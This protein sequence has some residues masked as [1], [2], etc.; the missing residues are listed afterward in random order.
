MLWTRPT[1]F[2]RFARLFWT[3]P[4]PGLWLSSTGCSWGWCTAQE[5]SHR[6]LVSRTRSGMNGW[7]CAVPGGGTRLAFQQVAQLQ[8]ATWPSGER[9]QML[10]LDLSVP[11]AGDLDRHHER[12]LTLGARLLRDRSQD[13]AEPLRVYADLAG[14]PFCIFVAPPL[15]R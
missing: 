14:H 3:A 2:P 7:F 12:A 8:E 10:H 15:T 11:T 4:T 6:P 9:P 13:P 5:T 1:R